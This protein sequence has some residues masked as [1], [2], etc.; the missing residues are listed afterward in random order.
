[1]QTLSEINKIIKLNGSF[2]IHIPCGKTIIGWG[3]CLRITGHITVSN[4]DGKYTVNIYN[5]NEWNSYYA[6]HGEY[7]Y[8]VNDGNIT[9][10]SDLVFDEN[11][12][13]SEDWNN[14]NPIYEYN[15]DDFISTPFGWTDEMEN[16][17][18]S[19]LI[20]LTGDE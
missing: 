14:E 16:V 10:K 7:T 20:T 19:L 13:Y 18:K 2:N 17:L 11:D 15:S 8:Y 12:N 4:N 1:M 5:V 9:Y 3:N 6:P